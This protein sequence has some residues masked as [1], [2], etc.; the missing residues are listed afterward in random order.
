MA[1]KPIKKYNK[2]ECSEGLNVHT[3]NLQVKINGDYHIE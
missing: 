1:T 3:D 2:A